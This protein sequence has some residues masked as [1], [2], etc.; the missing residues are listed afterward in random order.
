MSWRRGDAVFL[1]EAN[2]PTDELPLFFGDADG[3]A[4]RLQMVFAFRLNQALMLALAR[5][6]PAPIVDAL[7]SVPPLPRHGQ[8]ATFLRNHDEGWTCPA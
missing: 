7:H 8:W 5:Q 3:A 2:V 4:N 6:D 1:A